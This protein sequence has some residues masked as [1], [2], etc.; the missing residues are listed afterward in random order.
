MNF[1]E[2]LRAAEMEIERLSK[3]AQHMFE[4]LKHLRDL[5][6]LQDERAKLHSNAIEVIENLVVPITPREV[7]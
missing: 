1:E 7:N 5:E 3:I 6:D 4:T 2:R